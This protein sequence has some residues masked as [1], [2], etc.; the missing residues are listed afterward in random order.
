MP[1]CRRIGTG[2]HRGPLAHDCVLLL[3]SLARTLVLLDLKRTKAGEAFLQGKRRRVPC[4]PRAFVMLTLE[5]GLLAF[6]N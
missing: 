2:H 1:L 3:P 5:R 4:L 6:E